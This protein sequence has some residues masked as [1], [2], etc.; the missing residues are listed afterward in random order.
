MR[1]FPPVRLDNR[2]AVVTGATSG[3]GAAIAEAMGQA[4]ARVVVTGRDAARLEECA[5]AVRATGADA[6]AVQADLTDPASA[7]RVVDETIAA[8]G[9]IDVAVHSAGVWSPAP[10]LESPVEILDRQWAVNVRAPY[11]LT[12]AMVPHMRPGSSILMLSSIA[13]H[14]GFPSSVAYC[15]TKGAVE[16]L[17]KSLAM[18]LAPLRIRVNC[19]APG[20]IR[21]SMNAAQLSDPEYEQ[22]MLDLTPLGRVGEVEDIAPAAVFLAS[23][24]AGYVHGATLLVDGGW[25]AQ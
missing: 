1:E 24:A 16:L 10:F 25:T 20:N 8:F 18:E 7:A 3:I 4:G 6:R 23:D 15:A 5:A 17:T 22:A 19:I 9:A 2:T 21:T 13:G 14:I 12:R 11:A